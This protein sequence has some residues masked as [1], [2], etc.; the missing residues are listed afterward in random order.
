MINVL[1]IDDD[2]EPMKYYT[3]A[4]ERKGMTVLTVD[5]VDKLEECLNSMNTPP[6]LMVID[7]MMPPGVLYDTKETN[8]GMATG[9]FLFADLRKRFQGVPILVLTN[10][11]SGEFELDESTGKGV[12]K[13]ARKRDYPPLQFAEFAT[14]ILS[15]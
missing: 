8:D 6:D 14:S 1:F 7:M 15:C 10:R 5:H 12:A 3:R 9:S 2:Q 4:L 11:K 13:I